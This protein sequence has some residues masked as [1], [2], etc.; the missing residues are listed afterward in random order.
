MKFSV[1]LWIIFSLAFLFIAGRE[2]ITK[3]DSIPVFYS[4]VYHDI[5]SI[6]QLLYNQANSERQKMMLYSEIAEQ[7]HGI[8]LDSSIVYVKKSINNCS[9]NK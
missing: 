3:T 6:K 2:A 1:Q 5:D 8:D 7:Y 4:Y 9:K